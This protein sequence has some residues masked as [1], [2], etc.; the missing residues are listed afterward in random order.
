M[1]D[2]GCEAVNVNLGHDA[3]Q[4]DET[5]ATMS[6]EPSFRGAWWTHL[7]LDAAATVPRQIATASGANTARDTAPRCRAGGGALEDDLPEDDKVDRGRVAALGLAVR[8]ARPS[9]DHRR[10]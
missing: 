2:H 8:I 5:H 4:T 7:V 1:Q 3:T 6:V 9:H 10:T